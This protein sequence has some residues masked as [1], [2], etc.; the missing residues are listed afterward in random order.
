MS[1][2]DFFVLV[3]AV[4]LFAFSA[5]TGAQVP[6]PVTAA[7]APIPG[8]GHHYI[9]MG[10]ETVNP[11]D[12]TPSFD[13]PIQ[14]PAG[15]GL[16]FP[17]GIHYSGTE[18]F[19]VSNNLGA[20]YWNTSPAPPYQLNGWSYEL[21]NYTA[22]AFVTNAG[23]YN[24]A[25]GNKDFN[26]DG[27]HNYVFRG[28]DGVQSIDGLANNW[29]DPSNPYP[30]FCGSLVTAG[31]TTG[32]NGARA[33]LNGTLGTPTQLAMTVVD[34]SGTVYQFPQ[35]PYLVVCA[36]AGCPAPFQP[37]GLLA[38]TVTDRNGNQVSLNGP[39]N[40]LT[41][42]QA[43]SYVDTLGRNV[44][45]WSGIGSTTGDQL[46][47]AGLSGNIVAHW[48]TKTI[49]LPNQSNWLSGGPSGFDLCS[50]G[51][52]ST[53]MQVKVVS[54]I[55]LPN[56]TKYAFTYASS[57]LSKIT[58][59]GGGYVRYVWGTSPYS[60]ATYQTWFDN[61]SNGYTGPVYCFASFTTPAITDRYVSYDG[62]TEV[63][64]QHFAYTA[65]NWAVQ[66]N[67]TPYWTSR[68]TVVTS[69]DQLTGQST[70]T[71]Y[72]YSEVPGP[73]SP[74]DHVAYPTCGNQI[75][76]TYA[77]PGEWL[78]N[79]I[80]VEQAIL[81]QDGSSNTLKTVNKKWASQYAMA[82]E[83]T[84]LDNGLGTTE[85][86][87]Y[88]VYGGV[89]IPGIVTDTYEYGFQT[90]G[91]YPGDPPS[92]SGVYLCP[93]ST[94]LNSAALGPLRRHTKT[95]FHNFGAA[96]YIE[97][98]PDSVAMYDGSGNAVKQT[99][100]TYADTV[101]S[102]GTAV[103]LVS[104]PEPHRGNVASLSRWASGS[105]WD[106]TT[107]SYY[108]NGNLKSMTDPCGNA[109]CTD[110]SGSSHTTTYS[111][112]DGFASGTGTPPGATNAYLTTVTYPNTGTAHSRTFTWGYT[113]GQLRSSTDENSQP[114]HYQYGTLPSG[115]S[116]HDYL[117]RLTEI[118]YPDG[119]QT[120]YCYNDAVPSISKTIV[121]DN[122]ITPP[123]S[124]N[125]TTILDGLGHVKQMQLTTDPQGTDFT[126]TTFDGLGRVWKQ[127]NAHRSSSSPTDGS[128]VYLYDALGRN[129]LQVP[130]DVTTIPT[131]CPTS[132]PLG[133]VF[134]S[135]SGPCT[136]VTDESG[137]SHKA[138]RDGLGRVTQVF[139]DPNVLNYET[140]HGYDALNS[141]VSVTQN[142]SASASARVRTFTYD[143][144]SRLLCASNPETSS[145]ACTAAALNGYIT[146]TTGYNY[147]AN[148]NVSKRTA[149]LHN[150]TGTATVA[151]SYQYDAL[152]RQV[153]KSYTDGTSSMQY[154]YD[155]SALSG[156]TTAPPS[157]TDPYP[158]GRRTAMCDGSGATSWSHDQLG[159]IASDARTIQGN[160]VVTKTTTYVHNVDGSL[161]STTYPG[162]YYIYNGY[163]QAQ[164][165]NFV[166][167]LAS[168]GV[169]YIDDAT[170]TPSG[171][172]TGSHGADTG[173]GP[174]ITNSLTYSNRLQ[175]TGISANT[176]ASTIFSLGYT[177]GPTGQDNGNISTITNNL[178]ATRTVNFNYDSLNRIAN[179]LT[180]N[181]GDAYVIDAWGNMTAIN[182]YQGKAHESLS[183][184]P[185]NTR[186]QLNTCYSYDSAGNLVANGSATYTYDG[187]NRLVGTAGWTYVYD[188][189]GNRVRKF[190]GSNGTLYWPDTSGNVL[191]ETDQSGNPRS[192]YVFFN[193]Q[194]IARF[195]PK[196]LA[197]HYY[198]SNHLGSHTVVTNATGT[199]EQDIEYYPY[200][201]QRKQY[202]GTPVAQNYKFTG[203]ERDNES[204][205][206]MFG[207][208]YYGSSL[209]RFMTPDWA[210]KPTS[211]PYANF[212]NPQSLNL[213]SYVENNPTT[214]GDPDGHKMA[215]TTDAHGN[216]KC[217][218]TPD[219]PPP[220]QPDPVKIANSMR[221]YAYQGTVGPLL[222]VWRH[223]AVQAYIMVFAFE[224]GG[225]GEEGA[226]AG[227]EEGVEAGAEEGAEAGAEAASKHGAMRM[228]EREVSPADLANMRTGTKMT[229]ADGATVFVKGVG[230]GK[231]DVLVEGE[232][233]IVTPMKGLSG[234]EVRE[235]GERYGW[236]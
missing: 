145:A 53:S 128:T 202:C 164:R 215:C 228:A 119:G 79:G 137:H 101:Q 34:R 196:T 74:I 26:C 73:S 31:S 18:Q 185:A 60:Q 23:T 133:D 82:A 69:T 227:A 30:N 203:K 97:N 206:D 52:G 177:Y 231:Y 229:Q 148:G 29:N 6:N 114:T 218:V 199:C 10:A 147:D 93:S 129:C 109:T 195:D 33:T 166:G 138:C 126:D 155:G 197:V 103:G 28:L 17:F 165:T 127:S 131:T 172:L 115:C 91:T 233:G 4:V 100:Y 81:Y 54:E 55:D 190:G 13:L 116:Y 110:V 183:C 170:Y 98:A 200:G 122:S 37:W 108:D 163:D 152:N 20:L 76:C 221:N 66:G 189:D 32:D 235:L 210:A 86:L 225:E 19:S 180:T 14:T 236:H 70:I 63:L 232:K 68:S 21:P 78:D 7:Q 173:N 223:P 9:G 51:T 84:I 61:G 136:T 118:D 95:V 224:A 83:Q 143:S 40:P 65:P 89:P 146:G 71:K 47:V 194:R 156:C 230:H 112:T 1:R 171:L 193:G 50:I 105:T 3:P 158:F 217:V 8:V 80:P 174:L 186:N 209:G 120:T 141:L 211:V 49:S 102:S 67:G 222:R 12:G 212:G 159:R 184:G 87:C 162:G 188:G 42:M 38:Q 92:S 99:T 149:P 151:T 204:G 123:Y 36:T 179:A 107:Y 154:G 56:A 176:S 142:G 64:H 59:P 48:A 25:G 27:S 181:W 124:T 213:Y 175:V 62:T 144:L 16:S 192:D 219:P 220:Q 134:T 88:G 96:T 157:V 178:D 168:P 72:T 161:Q 11:A 167:D 35:G 139:E 58:F 130:Q 140:D 94:G 135:Y 39:N 121:I 111:Y 125:T 45:S 205:L 15:R 113:D 90:E 41:P 77:N 153:S 169:S 226:E 150:Q 234:Q 5:T 216:I 207:A 214:M 24:T 201:G 191:G 2:S 85:L 22:L 57:G 182:S 198:F 106:T 187:E 160:S 46:S 75:G 44:V 43:G 208:R 104:P 132:A 117:D